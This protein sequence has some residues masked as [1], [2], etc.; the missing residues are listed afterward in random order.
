MFILLVIILTIISLAL[1]IS[2]S[3]LELATV[4]S[5]RL[6]KDDKKSKNRKIVEGVAKIGLAT[7]TSIIR[8]TAFIVARVRDLI[9][10]VGS[11]VLIIDLVVL[12]V[13]VIGSYSYLSIYS[14]LAEEDTVVSEDYNGSLNEDG[15]FE[16]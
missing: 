6:S 5:S 15:F 16:E 13:V 14:S 11:F 7:S 12:I 10:Y 8:L 9:A 1:K 4:V 3:G 2:A